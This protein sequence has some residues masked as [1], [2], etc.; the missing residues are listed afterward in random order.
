MAI[1]PIWDIKNNKKEMGTFKLFLRQMLNP[2]QT[3]EERLD[4]LKRNNNLTELPLWIKYLDISSIHDYSNQKL[5]SFKNAP[6][7]IGGDLIVNNNEIES[8]EFLPGNINGSL[9]CNNN[10]I[11]SFK[12]APRF[13]RKNFHCNNNE[14]TSFEYAPR[15]VGEEH[16]FG[17]AEYSFDCSYNQISSFY[18]MPIGC[19]IINISNN[20]ISSLYYS[21]RCGILDCDNN[22]I[23]SFDGAPQHIDVFYCKGNPIYP[24]WDLF[25]DWSKVY[26]FNKLEIIRYDII[27]SEDKYHIEA[28]NPYIKLNRLDYFL[29]LIGK[30]KCDKETIDNIEKFYVIE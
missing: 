8:F 26:L 14:F 13:I 3:L 1:N 27:I 29:T 30:E 17:F 20:K 25:H 18:N 15:L 24:I 11:K 16:S 2:R 12:N 22:N 7:F 9:Y 10:K 4:E 19:Q 21:R 28:K 5:K 6:E 23:V